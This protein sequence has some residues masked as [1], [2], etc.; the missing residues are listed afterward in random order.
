MLE[1]LVNYVFL[2]F[3]GTSK[4]NKMTM[5]GSIFSDLSEQSE[6]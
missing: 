1:E 3:A 4:T 6:R 2:V 5:R